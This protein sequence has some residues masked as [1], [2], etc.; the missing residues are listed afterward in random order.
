MFAVVFRLL[1]FLKAF[2]KACCLGGEGGKRNLGLKSIH[3][4]AVEVEKRKEAKEGY[5]YQHPK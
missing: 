4:K 3:F 5:D 1:G 2:F